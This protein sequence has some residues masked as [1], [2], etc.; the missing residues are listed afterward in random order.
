MRKFYCSS[1]SVLKMLVVQ[2]CC[3]DRRPTEN[4]THHPVVVEGQEKWSPVAIGHH[5][6]QSEQQLETGLRTGPSL[7]N[8]IPVTPPTQIDTLVT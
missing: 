8:K 1:R 5:F 6:D 3:C 7:Q 4:G 2:R